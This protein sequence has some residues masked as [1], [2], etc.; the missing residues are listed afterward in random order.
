MSARGVPLNSIQLEV[1]QWVSDGCP[2]GIYEDWSHRISARALDSR[3]LIRVSGH[4]SGWAASIEPDGVY[5][6]EHGEY[7][8]EEVLHPAPP[9]PVAPP[10]LIS[11]APGTAS[12]QPP[13]PAPQESRTQIRKPGVTERFVEELVDAGSAGVEIPMDKIHLLRRRVANAESSGRIPEGM[14]IAVHPFRHGD[15]HGAHVRLQHLPRWFRQVQRSRRRGIAEHSAPAAELD[16]SEKF[17]V[18]GKARERALRLVDA[19]V[20]G[21][22][23][24]GIAVRAALAVRIDDGRRYVEVHRDEVVFSVGTDVIRAWFVQKT[25]QVQHEPTLREL[26][27]ARRGYLFPDF[28]DVPDENLT[29]MLDD[30]SVNMWAS[31]WADSDEQRL[32]QML[33]RILEEVLFRVDAA[34][35]RRAAESRREEARARALE[36]RREEWDR[37]REDA[38]DA[39]QRQFL[40]TRMLDQAVAWQQAVLLQ[41]Y[42]DAVRRHAQDQKDTEYTAAMD[43][44]EQ[45][46]SHADHINPLPASTAPTPPEPTKKDLGP[47]MGEHGPYRP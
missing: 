39:F 29:F 13:E 37:A 4:G 27:R 36:L 28:D 30:R 22:E 17:Q 35:A 18:Q 6:L 1:L 20:K 47:F 31:S 11:S 43:W 12:N 38:V 45:I 14:Q 19:L 46:E 23:S 40:I 42:A 5:Y 21:G 16:G 2:P 25:L 3:R 24:E 33:P 41:N 44:A 34:V 8:T 26:A 9:P 32:E 10:I 15:E 7:P